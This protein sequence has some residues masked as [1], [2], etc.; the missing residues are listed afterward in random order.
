MVWLAVMYSLLLGGFG[1]IQKRLSLINGP[2]A[3]QYLIRSKVPRF[4]EHNQSAEL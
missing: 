2:L 3:L 4:I 1:N